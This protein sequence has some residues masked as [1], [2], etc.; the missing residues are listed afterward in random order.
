MYELT[1]DK[2][3]KYTSN[4][5]FRS[6]CERAYRNGFSKEQMLSKLVVTLLDE[7]E[8][9]DMKALEELMRSTRPSMLLNN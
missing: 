1:D 2:F 9:Q 7:K 8:E 4:S 6:A 3:K 5:I